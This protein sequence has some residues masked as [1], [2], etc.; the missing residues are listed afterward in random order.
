[1]N[2]AVHCSQGGEYVL[3]DIICEFVPAVTFGPS[4]NNF[5][6]VFE[7]HEVNVEGAMEDENT[8]GEFKTNAFSP[9][10]VLVFP[11]SIWLEWPCSPAAIEQDANTCGGAGTRG[12]IGVVDMLEGGYGGREWGWGKAFK[13]LFE[14][15]LGASRWHCWHEGPVT[16]DGKHGLKVADVWAAIWEY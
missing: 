10:D 3:E 1:M 8:D 16:E 4:I 5:L 15:I 12:G 6:I 9:S 7:Y 13:P 2:C 11:M 14:V